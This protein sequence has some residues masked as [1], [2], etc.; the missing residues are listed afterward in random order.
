[1][2]HAEHGHDSV[3]T[4]SERSSGS[5]VEIPSMMLRVS[6]WRR[7][8][9]SEEDAERPERHTH[10]EHGHDSVLTDGDRS[11]G[12]SVEIPSMML[13]VSFC[14]APFA[15]EKTQSVQKGIPTRSVGTIA[16]L[17]MAIVP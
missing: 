13:R 12:S 11:S 9:C 7:T 6:F 5:S 1:H 8:A 15:R 3:L 17:R 16:F 10:A 14:A 2:T 4:D